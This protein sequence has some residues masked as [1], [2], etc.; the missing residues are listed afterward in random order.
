MK[1]RRC[2]T[3]KSRKATCRINVLMWKNRYYYLLLLPALLFFLLFK[4]VPMAGVVLAFKDYSFQGGI[5]GSEW[6]GFEHFKRLFS[7]ASFYEI[8]RNTLII[9]IY[10]L[11]L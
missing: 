3:E 5:F 9:S 6:V 8:L 11:I 10:K 1:I 4:Y 7:S 2:R